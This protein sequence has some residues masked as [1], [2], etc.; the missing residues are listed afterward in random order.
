MTHCFQEC[1]LL[2]YTLTFTGRSE[3]ISKYLQ[4]LRINFHPYGAKVILVT[5]DL[6]GTHLAGDGKKPFWYA[7]N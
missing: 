3:C 1:H 2:T 6:M 5:T 4:L 7:I